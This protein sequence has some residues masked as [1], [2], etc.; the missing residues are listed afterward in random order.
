MASP[1]SLKKY[2]SRHFVTVAVLPVILIACLTWLFMMPAIKHRTCIQHHAM[3][4]SIAGQLCGR[5]AEGERQLSA[6]VEYLDKRPFTPDPDLTDLLDAHCGDGEFFEALFVVDHTQFLIQVAG[7]TRSRRPSRSD[8]IGLDLSNHRIIHAVKD[9]ITPVWSKS[10]LSAVTGRPCVVLTLPLT[11]GFI[12]GELPLDNLSEFVSHLPVE[13]DSLI[14][15]MDY[16]KMV[17]ADSRRRY[18]GQVVDPDG[19]RDKTQAT[20]D[21]FELDGQNM[22]GAMVPVKNTGWKVLVAQPAHRVFELLWEI[23]SLIGLGLVLAL[24]LALFIGRFL[25]GKLS[26]VYQS[27]AEQAASV[28][29]GCYD[30]QWPRHRTSEFAQLG[31]SI[32]R[33][34]RKIKQREKSLQFTQ[35]SFDKAAIG[36][37]YIAS[38]GRILNVNP[39]AADLLGYTREELSGM[40]V[41]DIDPSVDE[42]R[43]EKVRQK[44]AEKGRYTLET[45]HRRKDGKKI[46]IEITT[47]LLEYEG[48][49]FSIGFAQDIT[50]RKK[51]EEEQKKLRG[52]LAQS[53]K[54]EAIGTLAG[55][56]AHDFN[57]ILSAVMGFTDLA[58]KKAAGNE[59]VIS[60]LEKVSSASLRARDLVGHIMTFSRESDIEKRLIDI[61]PII[62]ETV[63]FM[64]ASLPANIEI[65]QDLKTKDS[66]VFG[67]P[68]QI[69]QI[70]MNLF[71]NAGYAMK[72]KG[73]RLAVTLDSITVN[74]KDGMNFQEIPAGCYLQVTISDTGCGIPKSILD[75]VFDPF[76]TTKERGEGTGMGLSTVYGIVKEMGG[77]ISVY[78][79]E[80]IGTTFKMIVPEQKAKTDETQLLLD[81]PILT[82]EGHILLVD[83]EALIAEGTAALLSE[84]GYE[85]TGM[86]NSIKALARVKTD[87]QYFDLIL[88][89]LTMPGMTGLELSKKI[90]QLNPDI[91]ILLCTGFNQ[92]L[93]E[94]AF[95]E[96]GILK[97]VMKPLISSE[98][99]RTVYHA[100]KGES[101][102]EKHD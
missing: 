96:A 69:H 49:P 24:V 47:T 92:G 48:E 38:N 4:R 3:A 41:F 72:D 31:Q 29:K 68:T 6:L 37:Y 67:D 17:V 1:V 90:K 22:L 75:K 71:I 7:L 16:R 19:P 25:A 89:D 21:A 42:Q 66:R 10:F 20:L 84:M 61:N 27:F 15:I 62:R 102:K 80:G 51:A 60:Y 30:L 74:K 78:S 101:L 85:V 46:P 40:S 50:D 88:T 5:M 8:F 33:M 36:I 45:T 32:E 56:I 70:F 53:R 12:I 28:A 26:L 82:G 2:L 35:F 43:W 64:R 52:R 99:S 44:R 81:T 73:G 91:P 58:R 23:L 59:N 76:F 97:M 100:L 54:M 9:A 11:G 93:T 55:G 87:P 65:R 79:E 13:P 86:T 18:W 94:D 39:Y 77:S 57:N 98:L 34:A 14:L 83:D 63:K 95:K